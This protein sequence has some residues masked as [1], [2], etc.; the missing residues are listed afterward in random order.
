MRRHPELV[1]HKPQNLQLVRA[2]AMNKEVV[3]HWFQ[4]CLKPV[5]TELDLINKPD[6]SPDSL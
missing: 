3:T 1:K 5:L 4:Q 2:K 6:M